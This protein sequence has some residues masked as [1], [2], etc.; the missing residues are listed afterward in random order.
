MTEENE[1]LWEKMLPKRDPRNFIQ[2]DEFG[3]D[4][5]DDNDWNSVTYD[6]L[7]EGISKGETP[8]GAALQAGIAIGKFR[9]W[10]SVDSFRMMI[11]GIVADHRSKLRREIENDIELIIQPK[12]R[13]DKKIKHLERIDSDYGM[14]RIEIDEKKKGIPDPV[15]CDA[16]MQRVLEE[17]RKAANGDD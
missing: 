7:V 9:K 4:I 10:M 14:K 11:D 1:D 13:V 16:E 5:I 6:L 3:D 8:E 2:Y 17:A 12:D 15:G